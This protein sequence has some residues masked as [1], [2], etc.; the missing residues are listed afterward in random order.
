MLLGQHII[1]DIKRRLSPNLPGFLRGRITTNLANFT[2]FVAREID[3]RGQVVVMFSD[4]SKEFDVI[5][6]VI[7]LK[8][9]LEKG[10]QWYQDKCVHSNF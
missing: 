2:H 1:G 5:T 3:I 8:S 4:F 6:H 10:S 9:Y 7:F